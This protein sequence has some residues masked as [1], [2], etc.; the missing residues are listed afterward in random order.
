MT[1]RKI[2]LDVWSDY[3]CPFCY[4]ELP[5]IRQLQTDLGDAVAV[6]WPA[7]E[8]RP[9]PMPALEPAGDY[10][11][12]TWDRA[13]YPLA[14]LRRMILRLPPLQPRSR[15]AFELAA[16]ARDHGR[17]Q[18]VHEALFAA[19]F[20]DGRDIGEESVLLDLGREQG[21]DPQALA[22]AI[23]TGRY[24]EEVF[25]D[26]QTAEQLNISAVPTLVVRRAGEPLEDG[27]QLHG[28]VD[29]PALRQ[30]V[31]RVLLRSGQVVRP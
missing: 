16:F 30:A 28:A 4:L 6:R 27:V 2:Q 8:L 7:F 15:M 9:E 24:L 17:F 1:A 22:E 29:H 14:D 31:E 5:V 25:S 19:F 3:V 26:R 20:E 21:L 13:V 23:D 10:L 11:Q 12:S 18:A